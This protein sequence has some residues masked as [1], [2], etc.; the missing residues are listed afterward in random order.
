[1]TKAYI[2]EEWNMS[3]LHFVHQMDFSRTIQ[4][5]T[6]L[7]FMNNKQPV[8]LGQLSWIY[9]NTYSQCIRYPYLSSTAAVHI[10]KPKLVITVPADGP[11]SA[12]AGTSAGTVIFWGGYE[13]QFSQC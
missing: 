7:V 11:A 6:D 1:M 5:P 4:W 10:Q 13:M 9:D 3:K 8:P 2:L 12:G